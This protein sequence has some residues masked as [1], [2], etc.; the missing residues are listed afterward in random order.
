MKLRSLLMLLIVSVVVIATGCGT[1]QDTEKKADSNNQEAPEMIEVTLQVDPEQPQPNK[2]VTFT[3]TVTQGDEKVND[4]DEVMF[5]IW[6]DGQE[7]HEK[8]KAEHKGN[9]AY[10]TTKS[11]SEDGKYYV[12]SHVTARDMH[13]MPQ[14]E[15]TV[16]DAGT[17]QTNEATNGT[18]NDH[19]DH[20]DHKDESDHHDD[21]SSDHQ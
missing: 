15:F 21:H 16:G 20:D 1:K 10:M 5:E 7:N 18:H 11:F 4:A 8:I 14:K 2:K 12:I 9:G 19:N 6:R 3:A 17:D 13:N